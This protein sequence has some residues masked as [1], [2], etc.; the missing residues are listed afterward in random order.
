[1]DTNDRGSEYRPDEKSPSSGRTRAG[2]AGE[3]AD[4]E[5][6]DDAVTQSIRG[7]FKSRRRLRSLRRLVFINRLIASSGQD[8]S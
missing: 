1:M 6:N 3:L 4:A 8:D 5:P 2:S 7:A